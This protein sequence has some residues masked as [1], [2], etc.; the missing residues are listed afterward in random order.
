MQDIFARPRSWRGSATANGLGT[1]STRT[2]ISGCTA[3]LR[4]AEQKMS[5]KSLRARHR[6]GEAG[7]QL[8]VRERPLG[9]ELLEQRLVLLGD[10]LDERVAGRVGLV[11]ELGGDGAP[12]ASRRSRRPGSV[13]A[14]HAHQVD[15]AR[16]SRVSSPIG[17][18]I[19]S[20]SRPN[21]F[22]SCCKRARRRGALAV[23]AVLTAK[24]TGLPI[25][26]A[27]LPELLGLHLGPGHSGHHHQRSLRDLDALDGLGREDRSIRAC[28]SG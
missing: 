25:A 5:G 23:H 22:W 15:D 2:S 24:S 20:T 18:W 16:R 13:Y 7:D 28:R 19:G 11:L 9:E 12:P 17:S 21:F 10:H 27:D 8:V 4:P 3:W 6:F 26:G 1:S 14:L